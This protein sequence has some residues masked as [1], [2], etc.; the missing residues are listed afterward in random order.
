MKVTFISYTEPKK[1]ITQ[2]TI[3]RNYNVI[4]T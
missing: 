2:A 1:L 3:L 4:I